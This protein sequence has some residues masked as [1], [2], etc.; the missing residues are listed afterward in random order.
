MIHHLL[1]CSLILSP[2][3]WGQRDFF[4]MAPTDY[5]DAVSTDAFAKLSADWE[6]GKKP[7]PEDD[8]LEVLRVVLKELGIPE[9]SQGL[10]YSKTSK[11]NNLINPR[12]PR[13]VFFGDNAY[14]GYVPGG[15]I[16]VAAIDPVIGPVFYLL[17]LDR[18]NVSERVVR[19]NTCL[20]CH[21]TSRTELVPG[22]LVR[23]VYVN[24]EGHPLLGAGTFLTTHSS[25][26]K[27]RWGGWYVTGMHGEDRHMGNTISTELDDGGVEFDFEAGANWESLEGK[28]DTSKYLQPTSNIV[29][30]MVLEHQCKMENL[31][32]KASLEY[33]RLVYLQ[34][35]I[36][37]D[38]DVARSDGMAARASKD[39]AEQILK[40]MLFTDE[41]DLGEGV[42]GDG[43]FEAAFEKLG[44]VSSEGDS[45]RE[46]RLYGR[47]FKN[48]CSYMIH[49]NSFEALPDAVR[50]PVLTR[51]WEVMSGKDESEEFENL[52]RSEK[53]R[54]L[55]IVKDTVDRLPECWE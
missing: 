1:T 28:I 12:N 30:L 55:E 17:H 20:Q 14:V 16:E 13:S 43:A 37:P 52:G 8:P 36:N 54:I 29:S 53:K 46:F 45:L 50:V 19:S 11:Q 10:V 5:S 2:L 39:L 7:W 18:E 15:S 47:L 31:L 3:A 49:S 32:T 40:Y 24:D 41:V 33:R 42:E 48:R 4:E 44:P 6:S 34:K 27:E 21:G 51:L 38:A 25:P 9:E 22:L 35:A 23:S 26:L